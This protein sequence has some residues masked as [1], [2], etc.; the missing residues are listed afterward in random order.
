MMLLD[1]VGIVNREE[2][3]AVRFYRDLLG[4]EIIRESVVPPELS[5][6]LFSV[7]RDI[8]MFLYGRDNLKIEVF[9]LADVVPPAPAVPHFCILVSDLEGLLQRIKGAGGKVIAGDRGGRVIYFVEDFSGNR[10]EV[11]Q[12]EM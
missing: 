11:K 2:N 10:V 8:K 3:E 12:K 7:N 4:L 5:G 9:I 6:Q 1:H